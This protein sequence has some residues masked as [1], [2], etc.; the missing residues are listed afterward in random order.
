MHN[1]RLWC[2]LESLSNVQLCLAQ[3]KLL[4]CHVAWNWA[5]Q[6]GFWS[7]SVICL[8]AMP[9]SEAWW[10]QADIKS[11]VCRHF[12]NWDMT[13]V[14]SQTWLQIYSLHWS[15]KVTCVFCTFK[16]FKVNRPFMV[17]RFWFSWVANTASVLKLLNAAECFLLP[18]DVMACPEKSA[19]LMCKPLLSVGDQIWLDDTWLKCSS[20]AP[21][22]R[23]GQSLGL[24]KQAANFLVR[25]LPNHLAS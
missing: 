19:I 1:A 17:W 21:D 22:F 11:H 15:E 9:V 5:L 6:A 24:S 8:L 23:L 7:I 12:F 10:Q 13:L 2:N 3:L 4:Q 20:E 14:V 25:H 18:S 16:N